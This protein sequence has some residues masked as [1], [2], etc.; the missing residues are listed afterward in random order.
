MTNILSLTIHSYPDTNPQSYMNQKIF[1]CQQLR[2][3]VMTKS[4]G[5]QLFSRIV[6]L[7]AIIFPFKRRRRTLL[8]CFFW[9]LCNFRVWHH[10][11][12]A[13]QQCKLISL[14]N[15]VSQTDSWQYG[16]G[17]KQQPFNKTKWV[18]TYQNCKPC[19]RSIYVGKSGSKGKLPLMIH[20]RSSNMIIM[21]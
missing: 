10:L 13:D 6:R 2:L 14:T 19:Q 15:Y 11:E 3:Q 21:S 4:R 12:L 8:H 16:Y 5:N 7:W 17:D 18:T 1:L 20:L 9:M